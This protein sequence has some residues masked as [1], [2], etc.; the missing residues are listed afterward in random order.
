MEFRARRAVHTISREK[1]ISSEEKESISSRHS[2]GLQWQVFAV[3]VPV[4][5]T[6]KVLVPEPEEVVVVVGI[7][8]G[9]P[10]GESVLVGVEVPV[11]VSV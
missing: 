2:N 3:S 1:T 6:D 8:V 10:V 7:T 4:K 9:V 11:L 5:E